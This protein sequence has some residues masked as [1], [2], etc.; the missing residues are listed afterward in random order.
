MITYAA[1]F[2][3]IDLFDPSTE[4]VLMYLFV[5]AVALV[6]LKLLLRKH[7]HS[8]IDQL[9]DDVKATSGRKS[10]EGEQEVR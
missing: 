3:P 5:F 7:Y 4:A 1:I 2:K 6:V 8:L 10:K 9:P